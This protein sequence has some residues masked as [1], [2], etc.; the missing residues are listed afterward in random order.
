MGCEAELIE[1]IGR[2][3]PGAREDRASIG[4]TGSPFKVS[5]D[6]NSRPIANAA[7]WN[8]DRTRNIPWPSKR[9]RHFR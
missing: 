3:N 9:S 8:P 6:M 7:G 5:L 2:H 4:T 1:Q